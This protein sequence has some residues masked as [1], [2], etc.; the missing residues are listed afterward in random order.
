MFKHVQAGPQGDEEA[1]A[2]V[3]VELK[4]LDP[5]LD[6]RWFPTVRMCA[7]SGQMEGR[8][9]LV[10]QWPQADRRWEMHQ[11]GEIGEPFDIL[12]FFEASGDEMDWFSGGEGVDLDGSGRRKAP[13]PVDPRDVMA[14]T[15][16]LLGKM[17]NTR[18]SWKERLKK[19]A[20]DNAALIEK[21][22]Q[23]VLD[24]AMDGF[25]Y[26]RKKVQGSPIVAVAKDLS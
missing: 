16:E 20:E 25:D 2:V 23:A 18:E 5:L 14:K 17:D 6:V 3:R 26:Y 22:K 4:Q 8:Y 9:A 15:L 1:M 12:G 10:C 19:S 11:R 13:F 24:E 7:S 21:R